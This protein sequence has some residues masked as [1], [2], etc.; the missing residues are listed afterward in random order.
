MNEELYALLKVEPTAS[1]AEIKAAYRKMVK[2]AHPDAGGDPDE[3]VRITAA[4]N[5]LEDPGTRKAYDLSGE[6]GDENPLDVQARII[7]HI[8][9]MFEVIYVQKD[10]QIAL[11][12]V[13]STMKNHVA[14][15]GRK[16]PPI[17]R[18]LAKR[19]ESMQKINAEIK[20]RGEVQNLFSMRIEARISVLS[21]EYKAIKSQI[22]DVRRVAEELNRGGTIIDIIRTVQSGAYPGQGQSRGGFW[23]FMTG[24]LTTT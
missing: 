14:E 6:Y 11:V 3:F 2:T 17:E 10:G 16:F 5:V 12:D 9:D 4:Y 1:Q 24:N 19:L 13:I 8:A 15:L 7:A 21:E 18:D 23:Q 20:K 22:R